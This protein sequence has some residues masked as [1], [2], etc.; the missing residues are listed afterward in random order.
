LSD[1]LLAVEFPCKSAR[2]SLDMA[3][4]FFR[5][6]GGIVV[7]GVRGPRPI[8]KKSREAQT[9]KTTPPTAIPAMMRIEKEELESLSHGFCI[10]GATAIIGLVGTA[11]G[12][13]V[14]ALVG[15]AVGWTVGV[16][17]GAG[18]G[19][20][21]GSGVGERVGNRVVGRRVGRGVGAGVG[22]RVGWS[23]GSSVGLLVMVGARVGDGVGDKV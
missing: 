5:D 18:L 12:A 9:T 13:E 16:A 14:E 3:L 2:I 6:L 10:R 19:S 1:L 8:L 11:V 15:V 4:V 17:V 22:G 20:A 21:D 7:L 23:V